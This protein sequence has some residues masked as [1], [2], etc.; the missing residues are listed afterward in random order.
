MYA[1]GSARAGAGHPELNV[2]RELLD[3]ARAQ[4]AALR[5]GGGPEMG[6]MIDL[7]FNYKAEGYRRFA[8]AL[9]EFDLTWLEFDMY[10]RLRWLL[11]GNRHR[12]R[13][14]RSKPSSAAARSSPILR[15]RLQT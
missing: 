8:K 14:H 13:L 1:P 15:H 11:C 12:H 3:A 10:E 2:T 6:L 7:N 9:E 4:M 5:E